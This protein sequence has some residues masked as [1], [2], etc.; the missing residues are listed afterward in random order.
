MP[1]RLVD[2][3]R[4]FQ[5]DFFP[6]YE[7][8]YRRLVAEGQSPS[9][10]FIGCSDSR[11]VPDLITGTLPGELFIVRNVGALVP[12]FELDTGFHGVSAGIE[13]AVINLGVTDIVVCGHTQC[14]AMR[15]LY[16]PPNPASP[17]VTRWLDLAREAKLDEPLSEEVLRR[18]EQR[19]IAIQIERL[20]TFPM[21]AERVE[22]G[23]VSLHGW[24]YVIEEGRVD[25]LNVDAG[26]FE[27]I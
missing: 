2:G 26:G 13:F 12:P 10:L 20:L 3:L 6:R 22:R 9:T 1:H 14:G 24:H 17:H 15:A 7:E 27:P 5:R 23:D 8:H 16:G 11:V 21:V 18:T 25:V 19:S 4:R